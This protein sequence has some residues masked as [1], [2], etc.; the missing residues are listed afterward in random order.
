MGGGF[1]RR[2]IGDYPTEAAQIARRV[3]GPVQLVWS[4]EDDMTHDFYRP[5]SCHKLEGSLGHNG[6]V[7]AWSHHIASTS[8]RVKW[9][10]PEKVKPESAEIGGAVN[11]PYPLPAIQVAYTPV[12]S[13][14]PR[15]WWRSVE[16]SFNGF[17]VEC[18]VDEL[19]VAAKQDP[20]LFRRAIFLDGLRQNAKGVAADLRRLIAVLDLAAEKSGWMAPIQRPRGRGIACG[21]AYGYLAQVAEVTVHDGNI[22]VDRVVAAVDCGQIVNPDGVRQQIE[23]GIIFAL[24]A[25]LKGEITIAN[26][27]VQQTNFNGYDLVR[28]PES[29]RIEI[30]LVQ[31]HLDPSG[32]GEAGV[33]YLGPAV[34]NAI[35]AATGKRIRKLPIRMNEELQ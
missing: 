9:D 12:E 18:F 13:I 30:Y 29:P 19:A 34:A 24:S 26:G 7:A 15:G 8:I 5:A 4:R 10:P 6:K 35:F 14:V 33:P 17:A 23:G 16:H 20:Y 3:Y 1:G 32:I 2:F 28:M 22:Q 11:P 21:T 31:N 25:A 27:Q